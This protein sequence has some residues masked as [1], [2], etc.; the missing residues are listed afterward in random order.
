MAA[1]VQL[2]G[3]G[4]AGLPWFLSF[5]E[6][7]LVVWQ[8][9]AVFFSKSGHDAPFCLKYPSSQLS[10]SLNNSSL[11]SV[12]QELWDAEERLEMGG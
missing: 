3:F 8:F 1:L 4:G 10:N 2:S 5:L 9:C 12:P 6:Q 7:S 11:L